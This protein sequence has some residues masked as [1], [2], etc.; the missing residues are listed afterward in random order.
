[1]AGIVRRAQ[2]IEPGTAVLVAGLGLA[3]YLQGAFTP[4]AQAL[5]AVTVAVAAV[6]ASG[7]ATITR[8][9][10]P[11]VAAAGAL[12]LWALLAGVL[13][14]HVLSGARYALLIAGVLA[15]A[16]TCR[17]LAHP[18]LTACLLA[19]CCAV[20]AV[21]WFGVVV[22]HPT[23]S[24][25]SPGMWRASSTLTYPNATA[26]VL[27]MAAL[28]CFSVRARDAGPRWP[29]Y[30]GTALVTGMAATLSRA[31]IGAFV[32]GLA[33]L[34]FSLGPRPL[35]RAAAAPVCGALVA[36]AGLV[37][38]IVPAT[39]SFGTVAVAC[40]AAAAGLAV[41]GRAAGRWTSIALGAAVVV[42]AGAGV[43]RL[44][45][46]FSLDSPDRWG[47]VEAAWQVFTSHPVT[48]A[49]PGLARLVL[50]REQGG[51]AVYLFAHNEYVQLLAEL[52]LVG[53]L[54]LAAF[55]VLVLRRLWGDPRAAGALAAVAALALHAG[56]DFVWH[57]PAVPLL[58]AAFAGVATGS[59][60]QRG[61]ETE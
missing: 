47:A 12:A 39:P 45:S 61:R 21:G 37:P 55:L 25:L 44:G 10:V 13:T 18:S 4:V 58:A 52:G 36:T 42:A 35:W 31:G 49:G 50:A 15:V 56:F 54:L 29:G 2:G 24:F 23:W 19:I 41:G 17:R 34:A 40:V 1:M 11:V 53:G 20:A 7:Q 57:V 32:L 14:G 26:A 46:R 28:V 48:G 16:H 30:V 43:W 8:R 38:S 9:D 22:H 60:E 6:L 5:V 59:G 51:T 3:L 27:A 33:V